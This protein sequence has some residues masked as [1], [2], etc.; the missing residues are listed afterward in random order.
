MRIDRHAADGVLYAAGDVRASGVVML[1]ALMGMA[2]VGHD[3]IPFRIGARPDG[4][5]AV[6]VAMRAVAVAMVHEDVNQWTSEHDEKRQRV[7]RVAPMP[8]ADEYRRRGA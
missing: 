6:L 3:S 2:R 1:V 5:G 4:V 8:I 7:E